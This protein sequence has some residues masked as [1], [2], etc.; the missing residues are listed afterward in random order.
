MEPLN[1]PRPLAVEAVATPDG[2]QPV[3]VVWRGRR[4]RVVAIDDEWRVDDAWWRVPIS[5]HYF[6][7]RLA[8]DHR[9]TLFLDRLAGTWWQQ[10]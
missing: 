9:L 6:V 8:G 4:R 10:G 7:V 3:G 1:A 5:R 2:P